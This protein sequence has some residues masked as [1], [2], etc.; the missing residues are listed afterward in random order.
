MHKDSKKQT[1][2]K[3][4]RQDDSTEVILRIS[5]NILDF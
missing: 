1:E 2:T 4:D 5:V 3:L